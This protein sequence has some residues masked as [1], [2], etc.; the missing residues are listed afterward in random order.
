MDTDLDIIDP[1]RAGEIVHCLIERLK[2]NYIFPEAA[3]QICDGLQKHLEDGEYYD[4]SEG[5][6][7]ALALT[8]HMQE[9]N[10]D[11]HLWV[12]WHPEQLPD[13]DGQLRL[14]QAWQEQRRLETRLANYGL[15]KMEQI[16]G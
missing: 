16:L 13:D 12:H 2:A 9:I 8:V 14:N 4:I 15:P 1:I 3:A 10:H 7:L 11:E 5:E 6:F